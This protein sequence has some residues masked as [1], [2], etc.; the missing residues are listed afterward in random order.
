MAGGARLGRRGKR[1]PATAVLLIKA[2]TSRF[3]AAT[4]P[5][6]PVYPVW[7]LI[8]TCKEFDKE[9]GR[10]D[11]QGRQDHGINGAN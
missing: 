3:Y 8:H 2:E 10:Q 9:H 11:A 5:I 7:A 1:L 6:P 4:A